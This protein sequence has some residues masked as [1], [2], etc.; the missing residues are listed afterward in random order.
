MTYKKYRNKETTIDNHTFASM[1]EANRYCELKL[2]EK[3]GLISDLQLQPKFELQPK[4]KKDGKTIRA[5][6]YIADFQSVIF[7]HT[8]VEHSQRSFSERAGRS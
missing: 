5:I 4:F 6:N 2:L 7:A 1:G 8:V 3:A